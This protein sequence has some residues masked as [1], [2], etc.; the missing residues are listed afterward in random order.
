MTGLKLPI[1]IL[2]HLGHSITYDLPYE[3]ETAEAEV[4]LKLYESGMDTLTQE[5]TEESPILT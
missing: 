1:T 2:S 4:A 5:A 3:I